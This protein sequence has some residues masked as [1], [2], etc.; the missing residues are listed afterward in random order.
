[1]DPSYKNSNSGD[2]SGGMNP[3]GAM[4]PVAP[5]GPVVS[6]Q[7]ITPVQPVAPVQ[8]VMPGQLPSALEQPVVSEQSVMPVQS[9]SPM[10]PA[11]RINPITHRPM[12]S[13]AGGAAMNQ[14]SGQMTSPMMNNA[15][16]NQNMMQPVFP[17][18]SGDI[19][20]AGAE[21]KKPKLSTIIIVAFAVLFAVVVLVLAITRTIGGGGQG[22]SNSV[23]EA[24]NKYANFFLSGKQN[25]S[26]MEIERKDFNE[27]AFGRALDGGAD[28]AEVEDDYYQ[29]L[30]E[31]YTSFYEKY[32]N[33]N[34]ESENRSFLD[35][36]KRKLDLMV[37]Y[38]D[39]HI[40]DR[41]DILNTYLSSGEGA[42][43]QTISE[44]FDVYKNIGELYGMNYYDL[45]MR[46]AGL[47]LE[48]IS[49]YNSSGCVVDK[50]INYECPVADDAISEKEEECTDIYYDRQAII[51]NSINDLYFGVFE[52]N[53]MI[54]NNNLN[55]GDAN[56]EV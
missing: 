51:D 47:D 14:M 20:L 2:G 29:K 21:K 31:Y 17:D 36:Y 34:A 3:N 26:S 54:Y 40:L 50:R 11:Q 19:V 24:F 37:N 48:I 32:V 44:T 30:E 4:Q 15:L 43:K 56:E 10:Q 12:G 38:F 53:E 6:E 27:T 25:D 35:D 1:M 46:E 49:N 23:Q 45:V 18:A 5:A 52:I 39:G 7:P 8:P 33:S 16:P 41:S 9:V 13:V 28:D 55:I 22:G 42:A